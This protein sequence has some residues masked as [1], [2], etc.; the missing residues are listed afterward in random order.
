[1]NKVKKIMYCL[2]SIMMV[3]TIVAPSI[4]KVK[5]EEKKT[6]VVI[7]KV[8]MNKD[9]YNTWSQDEA[10]KIEKYKGEKIKDFKKYFGESSEEIEGVAFRVFKVVDEHTPNAKLG[11]TINIAGLDDG[12]YYTEVGAPLISKIGGVETVLGEG[13]FRFVEDREKSTYKGKDGSELSDAKAIPFTLTLP[14]TKS[15]GTG[16]FDNNENPLHVYP[17]NTEDKPKVTKKIENDE[18]KKIYLGKEIPYIVDTVIPRNSHYKTLKWTDTMIRGLDFVV[19]SLKV[20]DDKGLNLNEN[21]HYTLTQDKRGFILNLKEDGLKKIESVSKNDE[22]KIT[23]KYKGILNESAL[24]DEE[25]PNKIKLDYGNRPGVD[26]EPKSG[27]PING[28]ITIKKTW[29][30]GIPEDKK[31]EAFFDVYEKDSGKLIKKDVKLNKD[32]AWTQVVSRDEDGNPLDNQKEY[33]VIERL[34]K[35]FAPEYLAVKDGVFEIKNK[36]NPNPPPIEPE[37]PF[38]EI[39]GAKFVK[40]EENKNNKLSGAH[41]LVADSTKSKFLALKNSDQQKVDQELYEKAESEYLNSV[42]QSASDIAEKK[43]LRDAAFEK[44]NIQWDWTNDENKAFKFISGK[45]GEFEVKGLAA[46]TYHLKEIKAPDGFALPTNQFIKEFKLEKH[47]YKQEP[48]KVNNKKVDIPQ[49]GGIGTII[50]AVVGITL[51]GFAVY[52]IRKSPKE[53]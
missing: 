46:G 50:F 2:L 33:L 14:L 41:F 27:K 42:K 53:D 40:V 21:V 4:S 9:S 15:D 25:I 24:V 5:A 13:T 45:E 47:S 8:L 1:M 3:L 29:D 39:F 10:D 34:I 22:I 35:G 48:I 51:M 11:S 43:R 31:V 37:P 49:T 52:K 23:L 19:G 20:S 12:V 38:V 32:N 7:H 28:N 16:Y 36:N 18:K 30:N 44:L 26:S 17:K 6:K